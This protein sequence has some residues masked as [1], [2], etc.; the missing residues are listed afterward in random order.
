MPIIK[1]IGRKDTNFHQLIDYL[2][3]QDGAEQDSFTYLHNLPGIV[4]DDVQGMVT[5]FVANNQYRKKRKNGVGQ[6]HEVMSFH[7]EDTAVLQKYPEIVEDL[8][9]VYLE[10]RAPDALGIARVHTDKDHVHLHFMISPNEIGTSKSIRLT[11]K[12]F[13]ALRRTIEE[14]Q[15]M[16]YPELS[17]SY[18]QSR[19]TGEQRKQRKQ[20][21]PQEQ[22]A[23]RTHTLHQ[24]K[25]RGAMQNHFDKK[26]IGSTVKAMLWEAKGMTVEEFKSQ[27]ESY[28]AEVY[29]YRGRLQGVK[30]NDRKYRF[31]RL[32]PKDSP[33]MEWVDAVNEKRREQERGRDYMELDI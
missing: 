30:Y 19:E 21:S 16:H 24:M 7:P 15:L 32:L 14:Y 6:Y 28:G 9:Q 10:L 3:R 20:T 31:S 13:Q 25:K 26:E 1:S 27:I 23:R 4:S 12:Q 5:A 8:A 18:V 29:Y 17:Q 33:Q 11:K 2:H 22:S